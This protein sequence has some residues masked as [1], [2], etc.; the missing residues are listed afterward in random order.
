MIWLYIY[1]AGVALGLLSLPSFRAHWY[2][3]YKDRGDWWEHS[4]WRGGYTYST[5][6]AQPVALIVMF[7]LW[8]IVISATRITRAYMLPVF[9]WRLLSVPGR[10]VADRDLTTW[11]AIKVEVRDVFKKREE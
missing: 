3:K 4:N 9:V 2:I 1:L 8:P 6:T 7:V 5:D 11:Q 10:V